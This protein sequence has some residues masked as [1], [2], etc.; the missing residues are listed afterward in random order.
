MSRKFLNCLFSLSLKTCFLPKEKIHQS[1]WLPWLICSPAVG[2]DTSLSGYLSTVGV[3]IWGKKE[4]VIV[5][6]RRN[7]FWSTGNKTTEIFEFRYELQNKDI[8]YAMSSDIKVKSWQ[9]IT[10]YL[11]AW[12]PQKKNRQRG[13]RSFFCFTPESFII[14]VTER[15][16]TMAGKSSF[17]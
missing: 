8:K 13:S 3:Y 10:D 17:N 1:P 4:I 12:N 14:V 15:I 6:K 2:W 7:S 9:L 16:K 5:K 11:P